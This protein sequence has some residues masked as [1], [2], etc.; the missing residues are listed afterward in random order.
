ML[1]FHPKVVECTALVP[2]IELIG[3][4]SS[5]TSTKCSMGHQGHRHAA[6]YLLCEQHPAPCA[7]TLS[8]SVPAR[9]TPSLSV[10][11]THPM[12]WERLRRERS[13]MERW[14][15]GHRSRCVHRTSRAAS[16]H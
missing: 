4:T 12:S 8:R 2:R 13:E 3:A 10:S 1:R 9:S 14:I 15:E 6:L 7:S 16:T 11:R 5:L